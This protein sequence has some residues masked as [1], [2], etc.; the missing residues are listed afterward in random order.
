MSGSSTEPTKGAIVAKLDSHL[1]RVFS[2]EPAAAIAAEVSACAWKVATIRATSR[3]HSST[4]CWPHE[5]RE[6]ALVRHSA[7]HD[8]V[9]EGS[10]VDVAHLGHTEV[11]VGCQ[12]PVQRHLPVTHLL[13][14]FDGREVEEVERDRLLQLVDTIPEEEDRR[15]VGLPHCRGES[16]VRRV[17]H[18]AYSP[19]A[20]AV[21]ETGRARACRG[22]RR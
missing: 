8:Q 2:T 20:N 15:D 16:H 9:I 4:G 11:H 10:P 6:P 13:A 5:G 14:R 12:A 21:S 18:S 3:R 22:D 7:H 17:G 1:A 19:G